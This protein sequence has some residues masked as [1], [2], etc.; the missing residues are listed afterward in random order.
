MN[1]DLLKAV[2]ALSGGEWRWTRKTEGL[3]CEMGDIDQYGEK[4]ICRLDAI[5]VHRNFLSFPWALC[6]KHAEEK[7]L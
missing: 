6:E 5:L 1:L 7:F 4:F 3:Q 2:V